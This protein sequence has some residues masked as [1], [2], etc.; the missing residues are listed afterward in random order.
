MADEGLRGL[1]SMSSRTCIT[2][3]ISSW[4]RTM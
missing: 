1:Y 3:R 2:P 4:K